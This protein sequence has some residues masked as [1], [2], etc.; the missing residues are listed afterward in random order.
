MGAALAVCEC[1]PCPRS[2]PS[3][4]CFCTAV[5]STWTTVS[6]FGGT[7][8]STS[9]FIRRSTN[10]RIASFSFSAS[11][12]VAQPPKR[13]SQSSSDGNEVWSRKWRRAYSSERLFC[14]GVPVS[15][16]MWSYENVNSAPVEGGG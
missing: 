10:G 4:H 13:R 14:S 12:R 15:S 8:F 6:S 11:F 3:H 16:T 9:A 7:D 2:V 5:N 1:A